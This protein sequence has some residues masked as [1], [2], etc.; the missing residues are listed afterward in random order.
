MSP[1]TEFGRDFCAGIGPLQ[2]GV[3]LV[4]TLILLLYTGSLTIA[5]VQCLLSMLAYLRH[6]IT[7]MLVSDN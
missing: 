6:E 2:L 3:V 5:V 7:L 1:G 4:N